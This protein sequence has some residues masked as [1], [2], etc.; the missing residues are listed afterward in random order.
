MG[1]LNQDGKDGL[2]SEYWGV[3]VGCEGLLLTVL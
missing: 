1:R 2:L 3:G